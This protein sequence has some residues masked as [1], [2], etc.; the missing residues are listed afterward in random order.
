MQERGLSA[1]DKEEKKR[2]MCSTPLWIKIAA[3]GRVESVREGRS[4][5]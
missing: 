5:P 4:Y 1:N 2:V 3:G